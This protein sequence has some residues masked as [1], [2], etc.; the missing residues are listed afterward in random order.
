MHVGVIEV[1]EVQRLLVQLPLL[2]LQGSGRL[3]DHIIPLLVVLEEGLPAQVLRWGPAMEIPHDLLHRIV[4]SKSKLKLLAASVDL[5]NRPSGSGQGGG[6]II[7]W[8]ELVI[9]LS[10]AP[11][12]VLRVR[13]YLLLLSISQ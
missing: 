8:R 2:G 7:L 5:R 10:T 9:Q 1:R 3:L 4:I 12:R 11:E 6:V 13:A